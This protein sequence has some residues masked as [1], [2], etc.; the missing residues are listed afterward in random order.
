M[1]IV[2]YETEHGSAYGSLGEDGSISVIAGD[3]FGSF[4]VGDKVGDV[5]VT[6]LLAPI[7]PASVVCV[8]LNYLAHIQEVGAE[9]PQ[10]PVLFQ[11]PSSAVIGPDENV[12]L[13]KP[14]T[15]KHGIR[16]PDLQDNPLGNIDYEAELVVVMGKQCRHVPEGDALNYVLGYTCGN[17]V[18]ARALQFAEMEKGALWMGKGMDTFAPMGPCIATDLDPTNLAI[19]AHLNGNPVQDSNTSDLLFSVSTLI[20]YISQGVTLLP[21]DCV[22]TGTPAGV[23]PL[24]PGDT[25]EVEVEGVGTLRNRVVSA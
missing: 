19:R 5:E 3:I 10:L 16:R 8:G 18:S 12:I 25:I 17:D 24:S 13:P 4:T 9:N 1:R 6:K 22:F 23:G 11:K 20:A 15:F 2:R 7:T 21:G 14:T